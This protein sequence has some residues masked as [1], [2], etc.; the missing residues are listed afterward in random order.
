LAWFV[1]VGTAQDCL[2]LRINFDGH[3]RI[4]DLQTKQIITSIVIKSRKRARCLNQI[5]ESNELGGRVLMFDH[6]SVAI[7]TYKDTRTVEV[8]AMWAMIGI[9]GFGR[10][11]LN[12]KPLLMFRGIFHSM[13][14]YK[15]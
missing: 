2:L 3:W 10:M 13:S 11:F 6:P 9:G 15:A 8:I 7:F 4:S 14:K 12:H 1:G 5:I